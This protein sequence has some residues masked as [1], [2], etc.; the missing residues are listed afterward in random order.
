MTTVNSIVLVIEKQ[1]V[2]TSSETYFETRHA[3]THSPQLH[4]S[5]TTLQEMAGQLYFPAT[6]ISQNRLALT[7]DAVYLTKTFE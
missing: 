7:I 4:S 3:N 5:H 6:F 1:L 2:H